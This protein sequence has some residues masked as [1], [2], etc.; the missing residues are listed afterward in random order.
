[1]IFDN[2]EVKT[3]EIN[4]SRKTY[5]SVEY[6]VTMIQI[7]DNDQLNIDNIL[8]IDYNMFK[9]N[10]LNKDYKNKSI[11][12][13]HHAGGKEAQLSQGIIKYIDISNTKIEHNCSTESGASGSPILFEN[14]VLGIHIGNKL[15]SNFNLGTLL[16]NPINEFNKKY[17]ENN[18]NEYNPKYM[19]NL[20]INEIMVHKN[21]C[22]KNKKWT[23]II[24][25]FVFF[26]F[27]M[28]ILGLL[29]RGG[30]NK[31]K[32]EKIYYEDGLYR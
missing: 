31:Y 25:G 19:Q 6:D 20:E 12:I 8:E 22:E 11:Y 1:M 23:Y 4:S 15:G 30:E 13:I 32:N 16:I 21:C 9:N 2:N 18:N 17:N 26:F 28:T 5:T 7:E 14:N 10:D 27:L 3:I 29:F 24:Y